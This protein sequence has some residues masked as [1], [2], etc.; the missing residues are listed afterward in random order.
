MVPSCIERV[1]RMIA[2]IAR[3][4]VGERHGAIERRELAH[5]AAHHDTATQRRRL[6]VLTDLDRDGRL[7]G[8]AHALE[9]HR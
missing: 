5:R 3:G 7:E 9:V 4:G 6:A 8:G 1:L 2:P